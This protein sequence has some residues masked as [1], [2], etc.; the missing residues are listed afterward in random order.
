[1]ENWPVPKGASKMNQLVSR[2][3]FKFGIRRM[4]SV[5][6]VR[7]QAFLF[8]IA[9]L[10]WV[11]SAQ[12]EPY[13][14]GRTSAGPVNGADG[15]SSAIASAQQTAQLLELDSTIQK[16]RELQ[17]QRG[18]NTDLTEEERSLRLH[19]LESVQIAILEIDGVLGEISNERNELSDIRASLQSRRDKSVGR[20][21][22]AALITGSGVGIA[23]SAT[24]YSSFGA[25]TNDAGNTLGIVSGAASTIFSIIAAR[26]QRGPDGSVGDVPNMLAPLLGGAPVLHTYYPP[27]VLQ[28]LQSAPPGEEMSRLEQLKQTWIG[29]GRID[30]SG[31]RKQQETTA[32][33]TSSQNPDVKVSIDDLTNRIAMLSDVAGHVSLMKRDLSVLMN[34]YTRAQK[35]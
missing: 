18:A 21:T 9:A 27:A 8:A 1:M 11:A 35:K 26:R 30:S 14:R 29:S 4:N 32:A 5:F 28:Y 33:A 12:T 15:Q 3:G 34:S 2:S 13:P 25:R 10:A 31:G 7:L 19:L 17:A 16:L 24:Q 6:V 22:T 20:F 23:I